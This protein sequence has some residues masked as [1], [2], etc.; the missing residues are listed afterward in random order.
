MNKILLISTIT[1]SLMFAG[2]Q[3]TAAS[4][5]TVSTQSQ[6]VLA[7]A[8]RALSRGDADQAIATL[9]QHQDALVRSGV[10]QQHAALLCQALFQNDELQSALASCNDAVASRNS[11]WSDYNNRGVVKLQLNDIDGAI[12]DFQQANSIR[13]G[14]SMVR[15]NLVRARRAQMLIQAAR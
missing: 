3:A 10:A 4:T 1:A 12:A 11:H 14:Q 7:D 15:K 6:A 9:N 8:E 5:L 2:Q 13:P